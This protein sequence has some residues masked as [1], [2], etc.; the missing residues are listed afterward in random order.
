MDDIYYHNID[1]WGY[2]WDYALMI[3]NAYAVY[4]AVNL[5]QNIGFGE[6][7]THTVEK[8]GKP[9]GNLN[10]ITLPVKIRT[11]FLQ[12]YYYDKSQMEYSVRKKLKKCIR[13]ILPESFW[14]KYY[15]IR[16]HKSKIS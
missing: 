15:S 9:L 16:Y 8:N 10:S 13:K 12:D 7:A 4:P 5:V 6:E 11:D 14:E 1:A 2:A 3:N